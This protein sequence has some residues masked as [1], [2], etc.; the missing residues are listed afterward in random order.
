MLARVETPFDRIE[1]AL[2]DLTR[3]AVDAIVNAANESL[4]GGGGVDGAIHR[5]AGPGLLAE[6]IRLHP[7]GCPTGEVRLTRGHDLPASYVIH[8][9]G[10]IW[11]GGQHG[12]AHLLASCYSGAIELAARHGLRTLSFPA[13][14][15][16]IYRYPW[17]EAAHV[18]LTAVARALERHGDVRARVVLFGEELFAV[19]RMAHASLASG[20]NSSAHR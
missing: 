15:C 7:D 5:A 12:E 1:C 11:R 18:S 6:C 2:G 4:R 17:E 9:V 16:G 14:S 10:P 19:Y 3:E 8:A 13:I 20:W